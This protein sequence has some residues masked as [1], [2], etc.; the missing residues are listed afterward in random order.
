MKPAT[1]KT[2][3]TVREPESKWKT[4]CCRPSARGVVLA[5]IE[6]LRKPRQLSDSGRSDAPHEIR[7]SVVEAQQLAPIHTW[8]PPNRTAT[9]PHATASHCSSPSPRP[10]ALVPEAPRP[11]RRRL[12]HAPPHRATYQIGDV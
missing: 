9:A 8:P 7:D 4:Q 12:R 3:H 2:I 10:I 11:V 1:V 6:L 5:K